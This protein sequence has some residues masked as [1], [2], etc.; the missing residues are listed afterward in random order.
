MGEK[1]VNEKPVREMTFR[2]ALLGFFVPLAVLIVLI[3][4]GADVSIASLVALFVMAIFC[5]LM[6]VKWADID[7][8]MAE[9]VH[10][11]AG[12]TMVMLLVGCMVAIWMASGTIPTML[13]YGMKIVSPQFY[14]PVCFILPA[15]MSVCT[16]TSWGSISTIG[17]VLCGMAA[18]MGIPLPM[19]AGAVISGAFVGDKCSPLSDC[20]LLGASACEVPLFTH[21]KSMLYTMIPSFIICLVVYTIL[22]FNASGNIDVT[23]VNELS[24]GIASTFSISVFHII[25]IIVVLVLSVKQVPAFITFGVGIALGIIWA[26]IFQGC[27]FIECLGYIMSGFSVDSG[28]EAVDTLV[29]RG[30]FSSMLSLVGTI[31]I[32]GMLSGLFNKSGVLTV[33]VGG[34]SKKLRSPKSIILGAGISSILMSMAGGQYPSI[35]IPAV[36]FKDI[37]DEMDINRAVLARMLAD[38]G[39]VVAPLIFWNAWT[40]GYGVVLGGFPIIQAVPYTFLAMICP[41]VAII[42]NFLGIGFFHKDEEVKYHLIWKKSK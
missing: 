33:L 25:P 3:I 40:I 15:F 41:V 31:I 30:G 18:G 21:V 29:N 8:A 38:T 37:C 32:I 36:A 22:G 5:L 7:A 26:M 13:Y 28:V 9:G 16:G 27:G 1:T 10:Q 24:G 14:L 42:F 6:G 34:L 39:V 23:A 17:V 20:T 19:A 11:V 35:A 12:A 4:F 2:K